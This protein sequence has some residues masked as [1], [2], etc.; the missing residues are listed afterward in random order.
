MTISDAEKASIVQLAGHIYELI[1]I[2]RRKMHDEVDENELDSGCKYDRWL[3][4]YF[5]DADRA[6]NI[7]G[8]FL[9]WDNIKTEY[10]VNRTGE[11]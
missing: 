10:E 1:W 9:E 11:F 8:S 6:E 7:M 3:L 2:L 4:E 5:A